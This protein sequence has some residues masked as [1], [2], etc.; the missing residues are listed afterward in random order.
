ML[1]LLLLFLSAMVSATKITAFHSV[2]NGW[3]GPSTFALRL[4]CMERDGRECYR[5]YKNDTVF[6]LLFNDD[7]KSNINIDYCVTLDGIHYKRIFFNPTTRHLIIL[8]IGY[9][10]RDVMSSEFFT[11]IDGKIVPTETK[12][13]EP[14]LDDGKDGY[15]KLEN[16]NHAADGMPFRKIKETYVCYECHNCAQNDTGYY[17]SKYAYYASIYIRAFFNTCIVVPAK[18]KLQMLFCH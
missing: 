15:P 6:Y 8:P 4:E 7:H 13:R 18:K 5:I 12:T 17:S 16:Y 9:M 2:I 3:N 11:I 14:E 10:S 1:C